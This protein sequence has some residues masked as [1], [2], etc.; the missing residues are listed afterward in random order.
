MK[1]H[2]KVTLTREEEFRFERYVSENLINFDNKSSKDIAKECNEV[3][4]FVK[5]D[6]SMKIVNK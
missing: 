5:Q 4:K 3:L 6:G 2:T 1:K